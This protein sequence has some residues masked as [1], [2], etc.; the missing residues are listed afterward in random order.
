MNERKSKNIVIIALCIT[1]IFM[2]VGFS[3]LSQT[4]NINGTTTVTG[5]WDIQITEAK[6]IEAYDT[7][8]ATPA[9]MT[10]ESEI[11][12]FLDKCGDNEI[13]LTSSTAVDFNVTLA[14]PGDYVVYQITVKNNG[15][16]NA[17]LKTLTEEIERANEEASEP[18]KY[19][20]TG[21]AQDDPLNASQE[22]TFTI[23]AE[24]DS[25]F[26]GAKVSGIED[27]AERMERD[28]SL[29]LFYEQ[30]A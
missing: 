26:Y 22:V 27:F 1:L 7:S 12:T 14:Q 24:Y 15:T 17:T 9:V 30:A 13:T 2:G 19:T 4:L 28:Y 23:K 6:A 5:T 3:L 25:T 29:V 20:L 8:A 18:I 16:I 21:I 10:N 11:A